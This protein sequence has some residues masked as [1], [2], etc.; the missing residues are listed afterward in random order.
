V[1]GGALIAAM[2]HKRKYKKS[3]EI[4]N[5]IKESLRRNKFYTA[6]ELSKFIEQNYGVT[7]SRSII[8]R[9]LG[10]M[11][12]SYK[13]IKAKPVPNKNSP[14]IKEIRTQYA[15]ALSFMRERKGYRVLFLDECFFPAADYLQRS[16]YS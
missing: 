3:R 11:G 10:E 9:H 1:K 5:L 15:L 12:Y 4:E 6:V 8:S 7:L 14:N 13:N 16:D 2:H